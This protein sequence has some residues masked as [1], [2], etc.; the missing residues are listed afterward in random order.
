MR[1]LHNYLSNISVPKFIF[2]ATIPQLLISIVI[3]V[4]ANGILPMPSDFN[5]D[6]ITSTANIY[7]LLITVGIVGPF[8]ETIIFQSF[9]ISIF[10]CF[11]ETKRLKIISIICSSLIFGFIHYL[12]TKNSSI[13]WSIFYGLR[14]GL[15]GVILSYTYVLYYSKTN[16]KM[17]AILYTFLVH[18]LNNSLAI[19]IDHYLGL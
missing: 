17:K 12:N 18:A 11:S 4:I 19:V 9:I 5:K 7:N 6:S 3:I 16:T 13:S 10:F 8:I 14:S 1:K 2:M 15:F